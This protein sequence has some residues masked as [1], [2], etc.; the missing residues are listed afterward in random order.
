MCWSDGE[1][2]ESVFFKILP[3]LPTCNQTRHTKKQTNKCVYH[4]TML[5]TVLSELQERLSH[6]KGLGTVSLED[7]YCKT[8]SKLSLEKRE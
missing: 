1:K 4:H 3:K 5:E 2:N 7:V 8:C 6:F